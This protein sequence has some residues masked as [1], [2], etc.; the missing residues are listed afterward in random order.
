VKWGAGEFRKFVSQPVREPFVFALLGI[1]VAGLILA[2]PLHLA[3]QRGVDPVLSLDSLRNAEYL[4]LHTR[5]GGASLADGSYREREVSGTASEVVVNLTRHI[6]YGQLDDRDAAAVV[7]VTQTGGTGVF[8]DLAVMVNLGGKAINLATLNLGDRVRIESLAIVEDEIVVD[9]VSQGPGD[10]MC[11]PTQS[12]VAHYSLVGTALIR[13]TATALAQVDT[14]PPLTGE[15]WKWRELRLGDG[16]VIKIDQPDLYTL[17]FVS[18]TGFI[19][20][21]DCNRGGGTYTRDENR[22]ALQVTRMTRAAC[23]PGSL[24]DEYL[25]CLEGVYGFRTERDSLYL[26]LR[27]DAGVLAFARE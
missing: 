8:Y 1:F 18:D 27:T 12:I 26:L 20:R 15:T 16:R 21:A 14:P 17:R 10:P 11:C 19:L 2:Q 25:R 7:L 9:M 24:S 13:K 23:P 3:A 5:S 6:A 22:L 4:S